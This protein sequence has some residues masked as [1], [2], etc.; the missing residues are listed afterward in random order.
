MHLRPLRH[1]TNALNIDDAFAT[2]GSITS[3]TNI[4][5]YETI[6]LVSRKMK[7][8]GLFNAK[9]EISRQFS[10]NEISGQ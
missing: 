5:G 1:S 6:Y 8:L 3:L 2:K 7:R 4:N 10:T 9:R